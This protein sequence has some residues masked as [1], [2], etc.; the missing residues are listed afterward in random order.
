[1]LDCDDSC[2]QVYGKGSNGCDDSLGTSND[3]VTLPQNKTSTDQTQ[4]TAQTQ[5]QPSALDN[6]L[7]SLSGDGGSDARTGG[8]SGGTGGGDGGGNGP[9]S[10]NFEGGGFGNGTGW[11]LKG[12]GSLTGPRISK[13]PTSNG[14]VVVS[15]T[16]DKNGYVTKA[17]IMKSN[18]TTDVAFNH[19]LALE[20]ARKCTF[21]A[22]STSMPQS[23]TITIV[24][25]TK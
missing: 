11:A 1:V 4:T 16:V 23:G 20:A 7:N 13:K 10:G 2:P 21:T 25:A 9:G 6:M 19:S 22:S 24:L 15:I 14:Q 3:I 5:T 12:R 18:I 17:S 8:L